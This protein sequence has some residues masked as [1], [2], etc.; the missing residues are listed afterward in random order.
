MVLT[1]TVVAAAADDITLVPVMGADGIGIGIALVLLLQESHSRGCC[2]W[3][4]AYTKKLLIG[5]FDFK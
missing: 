3:T 2:D 5:L 4:R 1:K